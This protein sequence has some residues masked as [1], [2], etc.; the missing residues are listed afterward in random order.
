MGADLQVVGDR[1]KWRLLAIDDL[2]NARSIGGCG[3][4]VAR[5]VRLDAPRRG[6]RGANPARDTT[7]PRKSA[8]LA[9]RFHESLHHP[10]LAAVVA[11]NAYSHRRISH[12]S[13]AG[14]MREP[15]H[16]KF[17]FH[18][19]SAQRFDERRQRAQE[20]FK[21]HHLLVHLL[22]RRPF[23]R[24]RRARNNHPGGSCGSKA[25]ASIRIAWKTWA[26]HLKPATYH[27]QRSVAK[28][29]GRGRSAGATLRCAQTDEQNNK[30]THK[31]TRS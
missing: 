9:Q 8:C 18:T 20:R 7:R 22:A 31:Q 28:C 5:G 2:C 29:S 14:S 27:A 13:R 16:G 11:D 3:K 24:Q 10:P 25:R 1:P 12:T 15:R 17:P 30:R 21:R 26:I 19:D 4:V 23:R 6:R